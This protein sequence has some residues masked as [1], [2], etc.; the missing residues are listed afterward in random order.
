MKQIEPTL[1]D[2][3]VMFYKEYAKE[4]DPTICNKVLMLYIE[5]QYQLECNAKFQFNFLQTIT[6]QPLYG[7]YIKD[8]AIPVRIL[9]VF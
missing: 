7:T 9:H 4:I 8:T 3:Y 5:V 2:E 6:R 1:F